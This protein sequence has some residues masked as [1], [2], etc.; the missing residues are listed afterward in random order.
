M[1]E[2]LHP[3]HHDSASPQDHAVSL[4]DDLDHA[5][6]G[7]R[8]E[9]CKFGARESPLPIGTMSAMGRSGYGIL[10]DPSR[11]GEKPGKEVIVGLIGGFPCDDIRFFPNKFGCLTQRFEFATDL[12]SNHNALMPQQPAFSIDTT[13][14]SGEMT[15]LSDHPMTGNKQGKGISSHGSSDGTHRSG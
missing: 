9:G 8:L 14:K 1:G 4:Q 13:G 5:A 15:I 3:T 12:S 10:I 11:W 6:S 7:T 2:P